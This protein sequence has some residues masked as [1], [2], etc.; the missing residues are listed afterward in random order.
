LRGCENKFGVKR[1]FQGLGRAG[2]RHPVAVVDFL[3]SDVPLFEF[4]V[5]HEQVGIVS[6]KFHAQDTVIMNLSVVLGFG[7]EL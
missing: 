2:V 4:G 6:R 3:A 1:D 7:F 5:G